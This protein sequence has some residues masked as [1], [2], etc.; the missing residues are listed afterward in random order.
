VAASASNGFLREDQIDWIVE[1]LD[2]GV[3][4]SFDGLPSSHDRH[5]LTAGG[6]G[7]SER[8]MH[9]L[10]RFDAAGYAYGTG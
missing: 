3:S 4:V 2:G 1:N 8:V 10:R 6:Q 7:S 5:R 9:T